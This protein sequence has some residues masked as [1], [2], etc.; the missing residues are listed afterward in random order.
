MKEGEW[1]PPLT[2]W[3][4]TVEE[5]KFFCSL[6]KISFSCSLIKVW[7]SSAASSASWWTVAAS[8]LDELVPSVPTGCLRVST[9]RALAI[10]T[11]GAAKSMGS[12]RTPEALPIDLAK[13]LAAGGRGSRLHSGLM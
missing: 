6:W 11:Q 9:V 13:C 12:V 5:G 2:S 1:N 10:P 4:A 3:T 7:L 8:L